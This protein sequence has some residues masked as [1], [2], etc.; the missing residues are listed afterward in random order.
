M[1]VLE[2]PVENSGFKTY[3]RYIFENRSGSI[4]EWSVTETINGYLR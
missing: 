2:F 3:S 1:Y 4:N